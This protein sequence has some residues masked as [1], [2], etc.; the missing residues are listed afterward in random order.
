MELVLLVRQMMAELKFLEV[1]KILEVK[2]LEKNAESRP[3]LIAIYLQCLEAQNKSLP[4]EFV[5][6]RLESLI[7]EDVDR[8]L[9]EISRLPIDQRFFRRTT[10]IKAKIYSKLGFILEL[11]KTLI[12]YYLFLIESR[13]PSRSSFMDSLA[14][15]YFK[16]DFQINLQLLTLSLMTHDLE[17]S[18]KIIHGLMF[19]SLERVSQ[20]GIK[21]KMSALEIILAPY[22]E[23]GP[24]SLYRN[25]IVLMGQGIKAKSD[26]KRLVESIIYFESFKIQTLILGFLDR[27]NLTELASEYA[28]V[29]KLHPDYDFVYFDK[30]F[31]Q[32][33]SYF[34]ARKKSAQVVEQK[35]EIDL[36]LL[37]PKFNSSIE[38]EFEDQ[39]DHDLDYALKFQD[40]TTDQ[41]LDLTV[42]FIQCDLLSTAL[43][44]VN[45]VFKK[46]LSAEDFLK[47][48]YLKLTCLL[49][50]KDYRGA[51]DVSLVALD[52]SSRQNDLLSFLYSQ[53]EA[54]IH[55]DK[56]RDAVRVL[57][58]IISLDPNYRLTQERLARLDEI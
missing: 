3:E 41:L 18:E 8:A 42:S 51:L 14:D 11:K 21:E 56:K 57:K 37:E 19:N 45:L 47:A 36:R 33:K 13:I 32:L 55:L 54:L 7:D 25:L 52:K 20:K 49:R 10:F 35:I 30:F 1:Q 12:N 28:Q 29:I 48:S 44:A 17:R 4:S 50:L 43:K 22:A 5:L 58:K 24:L 34:F 23:S 53:A 39:E 38:S 9:Q 40:Y 2:L 31:P 26:Y 46:D 6:E 27:E 16:N 15:K